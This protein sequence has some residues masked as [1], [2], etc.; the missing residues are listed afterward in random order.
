MI[1]YDDFSFRDLVR[2]VTRPGGWGGQHEMALAQ[3]IFGREIIVFDIRETTNCPIAVTLF[4]PDKKLKSSFDFNS[5][6]DLLKL[7]DTTATFEN[8][9]FLLRVNTNH[10]DLLK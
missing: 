7:K 1:F 10:F 5:P 2:D 9:I 8:P 6:G 3:H 4:A